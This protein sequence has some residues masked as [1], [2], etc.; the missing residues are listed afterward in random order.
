MTLHARHYGW[1]NSIAPIA[2]VAS[3]DEL[4]F[5]LQEASG[6][7]VGRRS[8]AAA[9]MTLDFAKINAVTGPVFVKGAE[10]GDVLEVEIRG[11]EGETWGWTGIIPGFGL[12]HDE[13]PDPWLQIWKV[14][15]RWATGI[16]DVKIPV[17][18]FPGTIG[19]ALA[20]SGSYS[21]IP[22]RH[23]G[24]NMDIRHLTEGVKVFLPVLVPGALFSVGDPHAAQG[25][26]EVCGVAIESPANVTLR[27]RLIKGYSIAEPQ[28]QIPPGKL[29]PADKAG[30]HVTTGI[31]N[32][33]FAA[34]R[35]AVRHMI[36]YLMRTY[37]YDRNEAYALASVAVDLRISEIV[38]APNWCVSAF[39]PRSIF[40]G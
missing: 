20:E 30:Y 16:R 12:L 10:P 26:G 40:T 13:Y 23:N 15:K 36:T 25:D 4:D 8:N 29:A 11:I 37:S 24:G 1:D 2:A 18:R 28:Y 3:G 34:S 39:L 31:G 17:R 14:G 38:D 19:V 21:V 35:N 7:Q 33:L 22:P 9:L 5:E 27:F 32:D 6:G